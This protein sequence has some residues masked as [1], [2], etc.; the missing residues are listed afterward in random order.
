[1]PAIGIGLVWLAYAGSLY[2][3]I[4][5]KG[6]NVSLKELMSPR[7]PPISKDTDDKNAINQ[8]GGGK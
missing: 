3:W 5:M 6:Y 7:W 2:G 8:Q 1:M 4:L